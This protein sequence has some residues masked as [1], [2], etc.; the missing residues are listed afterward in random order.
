MEHYNFD[1]QAITN[2]ENGKIKSIK[3]IYNEENNKYNDFVK[4]KQE[5][6]RL[7]KVFPQD[8]FVVEVQNVPEDQYQLII[9]EYGIGDEFTNH[10][11]KFYLQISINSVI[12]V[13]K[14][15]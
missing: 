2:R 3:P 1:R 4:L 10:V 13:H 5:L 12:I 15:Y 11:N 7:S 8:K 9:D 14:Q 6:D